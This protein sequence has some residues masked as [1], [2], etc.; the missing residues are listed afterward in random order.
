MKELKES[1]SE[2]YLEILSSKNMSLSTVPEK[3]IK[4]KDSK[5]LRKAFLDHKGCDTC[6]YVIDLGDNGKVILN[7]EDIDENYIVLLFE[8]YISG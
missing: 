4:F 1:T 8:T 2:Y 7:I 5:G 3:R 6:F